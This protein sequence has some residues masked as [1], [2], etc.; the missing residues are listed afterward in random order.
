MDASELTR[1]RKIRTEYVNN[2]YRKNAIAAGEIN[3]PATSGNQIGD[4]NGVNY[5][6]WKNYI[7]VGPTYV[8]QA[9]LD[10]IFVQPAPPAP[11]PV[12]NATF[13]VF[14]SMPTSA[15][16]VYRVY[17][18][19]TNTWTA[20]LDTGYPTATWSF[21]N[22][23]DYS[24]YLCLLL[25][26]SSDTRVFIF[27]DAQGLL[28]NTITV[29][30][31]PINYT[32]AR[33][34]V[35]INDYTTIQMY[36]PLTQKLQTA[37]LSTHNYDILDNGV[38][39]AGDTD[40]SSNI[41]YYMWPLGSTANPVLIVTHAETRSFNSYSDALHDDI[42]LLLTYS[43]ASYADN[44]YV[45]FSNGTFS[46]YSLPPHTY[47]DVYLRTYGINNKFTF[48]KCTASNN[49]VTYYTFPNVLGT[50]SPKVIH[51]ANPFFYQEYYYSDDN[52][53]PTNHSNHLVITNYAPVSTVSSIA[54]GGS[55]P[56]FNPNNDFFGIGSNLMKVSAAKVSFAE[57]SVQPYF[58]IDCG[59]YGS[60]K[61]Y[62]DASGDIAGYTI[63][64]DVS[65][66]PHTSLVYV[67][68]GF[69]QI[70]VTG[71]YAYSVDNGNYHLTE[72]TYMTNVSRTSQ[73]VGGSWWSIK[74]IAI[75]RG[76]TNC[77]VWFTIEDVTNWATQI[78]DYIDLRQD[79]RNTDYYSSI[80]ISGSNFV[81]GKVLFAATENNT[82]DDSEIINYLEAYV[83]DA[84]PNLFSDP[85]NYATISGEAFQAWHDLSGAQ[86]YNSRLEEPYVYSYDSEGFI[87]PQFA[88]GT[89][90]IS[91]SGENFRTINYTSPNLLSKH[92]GIN[93]TGVLL[94]EG[95]SNTDKQ[96]SRWITAQTPLNG[97]PV[98]LSGNLPTNP[99]PVLDFDY[100]PFSGYPWVFPTRQNF[101]YFNTENCF[102][103]VNFFP[104]GTSYF[105]FD[106]TNT[107]LYNEFFTPVVML[108]SVFNDLV[109]SGGNSAIEAFTLLS[110][111]Y[112][113]DPVSAYTFYL[114]GTTLT[115][116][117][118]YPLGNINT[119]AYDNGSG[120]MFGSL[121]H[122]DDISNIVTMTNSGISGATFVFA[123]TNNDRSMAMDHFF[124]IGYPLIHIYT[125][126][127]AGTLYNYLPPIPILLGAYSYYSTTTKI[128]WSFQNDNTGVY[129]YVIFDFATH[130]YT[131]TISQSIESVAATETHPTGSYPYSL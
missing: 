86:Y 34:Y 17:N 52:P 75:N 63:G 16:W 117:T 71:T 115:K 89:A 42:Y 125:W 128:C 101:L 46:T 36:D 91:I 107:V 112:S 3:K 111:Y 100:G 79:S 103:D 131:D 49:S 58:I 65:G 106:N 35:F 62:T 54:T 108:P 55:P 25:I 31:S 51:L 24:N 28:V 116:Y 67:Q 110:T 93:E 7:T 26:N 27:I 23:S 126:D 123:N 102:I 82:I 6:D 104:V 94:I 99:H 13:A 81:L 19:T 2:I 32:F 60:Q 1:R 69:G 72:G 50:I 98:D 5:T 87:P 64:S 96:R 29:T 8:T 40:G 97:E 66:N 85:T 119:N 39:I 120:V 47:A 77:E 33:N 105:A 84:V 73:V 127:S 14:A 37:T 109:Q 44:V 38:F 74:R 48:L 30:A 12:Y 70:G 121:L 45:I 114:H 18:A 53:N 43:D 10:A 9:E 57:G 95:N 90:Y 21:Q 22:R 59:P 83:A 61:K 78:D 80:D 11:T 4:K 113:A 56:I 92:I 68:N 15:N 41:S 122:H 130:T 124:I 118:G 20:L 129:F 88:E 76:P